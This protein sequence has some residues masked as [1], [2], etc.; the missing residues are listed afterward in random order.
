MATLRT[1]FLQGFE[2]TFDKDSWG[3]G[4]KGTKI[5]LS[6]HFFSPTSHLLC[7]SGQSSIMA[8]PGSLT[9]ALFAGLCCHLTLATDLDDFVFSDE[10]LSQFSWYHSSS[11][12]FEGTNHITNVDYHAYV[13]NMTSGD[14]LTGKI[15][16]FSIQRSRNL[17][18]K[19]F[20]GGDWRQG[21]LVAHPPP[22]N[23]RE[24]EP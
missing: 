23:S 3:L 6:G 21:P 10:S 18:N 1:T 22:G 15:R 17:S 13:I 11:Y 14:W 24:L 8:R 16:K 9:L 19:L 2:D 12:D 4:K 20:R 5:S 7:S